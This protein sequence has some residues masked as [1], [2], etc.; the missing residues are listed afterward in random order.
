MLHA[1]V[2]TVPLPASQRLPLYWAGVVIVNTEVWFPPAQAVVQFDQSLQLPLQL[3][4]QGDGLVQFL[5]N[6]WQAVSTHAASIPK[7][8]ACCSTLDLAGAPWQNRY[9]AGDPK[10]T[11]GRGLLGMQTHAD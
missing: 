11:K 7:A 9:A 3:I 4:G 2:R 8:L 10:L 1:C 5:V 6:L